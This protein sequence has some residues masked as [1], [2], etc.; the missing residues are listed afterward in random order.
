MRRLFITTCLLFILLALPV[1]AHAWEWSIDEAGTLEISGS[2]PVE[3]F[4]SASEAPWYGKTVKQVIV[5]EGI[6]EIGSYAF[7]NCTR[8]TAATLP[9]SLKSLG[10]SAFE[11]CSALKTLTIGTGLQTIE[12]Y[13]FQDCTALTGVYITDVNAWCSIELA[14]YNS[15]PMYYAKAL[16]VDGQPLSGRLEISAGVTM[17]SKYAFYGCEGITELYLPESVRRIDSDAF[18]YCS[19][20]TYADLGGATQIGSAAFSYCAA[21]KNVSANSAESLGDYAFAYCSKLETAV[22]PNTLKQLGQRV[23]YDCVCLKEIQL[24]EGLEAMGSYAFYGCTALK[25]VS[26]PESLT[27]IPAYSFYNCAGLAEL[28]L[29]DTVTDIQKHAFYGCSSL[30]GLTIPAGLKTLGNYAFYNCTGLREIRLEAVAMEDLKAGNYAFYK[31]GQPGMTVTVAAAVTHIPAYLFYPYSTYAPNVTKVVFEKGS[32]CGT[33][34]KY[35]FAS[36]KTLK[37]VDFS[38]SAPA[39]GANAFS[40]VT[41]VCRYPAFW[42]SAVLQNYGGALTWTPLLVEAADGALYE[43]FAEALLYSDRLRLLGNVQ[44]DAM[45]QKDLYID[46]NGCDISGKLVSGGYKVYGM[47]SATDSYDSKNTGTFNCTGAVPEVHCKVDSKRYLTVQTGE[48][49]S[50]HR[51]YM[52]IT[53]MTLRPGQQGAGFKAVFYGDEA[54]QD[55]IDA[56]GYTLTLEGF[57]SKSQWKDG[58]FASGSEIRMLLKHFDA[59][60]GETPLSASLCLRLKDGTVIESSTVTMTLRSLMEQLSAE[61]LTEVQKQQIAQWVTDSPTMGKWNIQELFV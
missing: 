19:G 23:F 13:A 8:M 53:H 54:V 50:F 3:D 7:R 40:K 56:T 5:H 55:Q 45:L 51:F 35:A 29:P 37:E 42:D 14:A 59:A 2:G 6:T 48:G 15:S 38:G 22:L 49:Y 57:T 36:C 33:V 61:M 24:P 32:V 44:T 1:C 46:L 11:G 21:L 18:T 39:F 31:A 60:Y 58:A 26:L 12:E 43:T 27:V 17:I 25:S 20:L 28:H 16:Y 41:A 34:G 10:V 30:I 52:G 47:D 9:D 4:G